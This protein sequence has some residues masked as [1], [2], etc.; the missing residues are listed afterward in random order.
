MESR[1]PLESP[2]VLFGVFTIVNC[3]IA[4]K[5]NHIDDTDESYGYWEVLH[6][7]LYGYGMQTW[8]YAPKF[9][10][11]TYAFLSPM[12]I[13]GFLLKALFGDHESS[14]IEVFLGIRILLGAFTALAQTLFLLGIRR[15][16]PSNP[17]VVRLTMLFLLFS[18]GVFFS[19]TSFLPSAVAASCVMLSYSQLHSS[20]FLGSIFWGC[21]GVLATGWPFVGIV[22]L[23]VGVQMIAQTFSQAKLIG[24][25]RLGISGMGML[26]LVISLAGGIDS[27]MYRRATSPTLN[28]FMYNVLGSKT[29]D[30]LY[31]IEPPSYY[32]RNLLLNLGIAWP[33][34]AVYPLMTIRKWL[35]SGGIAD[36]ETMTSITFQASALLWLGLLFMR[37]H[38]EERFL[39]PIYS[40]LA[41][42]AAQCLVELI[43]MVGDLTAALLGEQLPL[44]LN[45]LVLRANNSDSAGVNGKKKGQRNTGRSLAELCKHACLAL[46]LLAT[47]SLGCSRIMSNATNYGGYL[48]LWREL[49]RTLQLPSKSNPNSRPPLRRVQVCT[50]GEWYYFPSHFF[51]PDHV[52]LAFV[53]DYFH[54][55]LPAPFLE[56][57][58]GTWATPQHPFNNI[59]SEEE[60][61]YAQLSSCDYVVA[62]IDSDADQSSHGP[63]V[64]SMRLASMEQ[65][66]DGS[67]A[68]SPPQAT[69]S[70]LLDRAVLD[71]A[72]SHSSIARA[73]FIPFLSEKRNKFNK[74]TVFSNVEAS[75]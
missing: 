64:S 50:G 53:K 5:L 46:A 66:K 36:A 6:Y 69:F 51:L 45:D 43:D 25:L 74:Y 44:P 68:A 2:L 28:I 23:P 62:I 15:S 38:K 59:N 47:V 72:R 37:P 12:W 27:Y 60:S 1:N 32:I 56:H 31:G 20:R 33:L 13:A 30:E 73:F 4:A 52:R 58:Q 48:D 40:I 3:G 24:V 19:S 39:Y 71:P 9:A 49:G 17:L 29:G 54:G 21:L 18:P 67:T 14:K 10:I 65:P 42:M 57:S 55:Q 7:L 61:R 22:F 26:L 75:L 35:K 41:Y 70:F 16:H 11:R 63:M 8:E 34:A